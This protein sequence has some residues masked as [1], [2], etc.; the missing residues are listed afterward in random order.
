MGM[1]KRAESRQQEFW[2]ATEALTDAPRHVFY[3]RLNALLAE[4]GFDRFVESICEM[5]YN[6]GGRP[7]IPPG[8]YFRMLLVGTLKIFPL[9]EASRGAAPTV[10][11]SGSF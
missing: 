11:L 2:V 4:A 5:Y 10:F 8:T 1:G 9:S 7:S 6:E 3:D